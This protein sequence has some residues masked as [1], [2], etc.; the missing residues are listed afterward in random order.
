MGRFNFDTIRYDYYRDDT[1]A[2]EAFKGGA[3][4]IRQWEASAKNWAK[5]YVV[6]AVRDG[7][8]R[9]AQ[10]PNEVPNSTTVSGRDARTSAYRS[11][12]ASGET[13]M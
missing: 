8:I 5:A 12:P 6:A 3:Y 2:L 13:G 11:L 10:I 1:V 7:R 9:K 4:D